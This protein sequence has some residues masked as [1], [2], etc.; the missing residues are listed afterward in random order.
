MTKTLKYFSLFITSS[1]IVLGC[2]QESEKT[3]T[4]TENETTTGLIV[5]PAKIEFDGKGL[6]AK[7]FEI[8]FNPDELTLVGIP[9]EEGKVWLANGLFV[10]EPEFNAQKCTQEIALGRICELQVIY[11]S[12]TTRTVA[13]EEVT[14]KDG[15]ATDIPSV[16]ADGEQAKPADSGY[17]TLR[18][19]Y[20]D[21]PDI[22]YKDQKFEFG[23]KK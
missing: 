9:K 2:S 6:S 12:K 18:F 15:Q 16:T 21:N 22:D 4:V 10:I 17:V 23:I 19:F 5:T 3:Y 20:N 13:K 11:N 14:A 7:R 8:K 1:L